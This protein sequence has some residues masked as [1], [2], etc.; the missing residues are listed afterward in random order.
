MSKRLYRTLALSGLCCLIL[1]A[2]KMAS[3]HDGCVDKCIKEFHICTQ[4][5]AGSSI[6]KHECHKR[7]YLEST[8]CWMDCE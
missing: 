5:C 2:P 1:G 4:G 3:A 6:E 8:R 7:C